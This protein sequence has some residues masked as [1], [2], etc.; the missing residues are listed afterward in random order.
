MVVEQQEHLVLP[1]ILQ[2]LFHHV[3]TSPAMDGVE[4]AA[5]PSSSTEGGGVGTVLPS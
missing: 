2:N 4:S 3:V 5:T 1:E